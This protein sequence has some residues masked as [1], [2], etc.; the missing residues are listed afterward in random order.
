MLL[1]PTAKKF[2]H[3]KQQPTFNGKTEDFQFHG[4]VENDMKGKLRSTTHHVFFSLYFIYKIKRVFSTAVERNACLLCWS[5][6]SFSVL[7]CCLI[8]L[9]FIP[10]KSTE[11]T[12]KW[13]VVKGM[14]SALCENGEHE[15]VHSFCH[16]WKTYR[17]SFGKIFQIHSNDTNSVTEVTKLAEKCFYFVWYSIFTMGLV[18]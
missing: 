5:N 13:K 9:I 3:K 17:K 7:L 18:K 2:T 15:T 4:A 11:L 16:K 1:L 8:M 6:C 12:W 10:E 14:I